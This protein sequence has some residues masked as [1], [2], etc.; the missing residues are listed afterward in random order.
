MPESSR[1]YRSKLPAFA[2][3]VVLALGMLMIF[4]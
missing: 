3:M 4:F 2:V 1:I